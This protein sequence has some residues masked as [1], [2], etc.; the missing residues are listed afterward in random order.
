MRFKDYWALLRDTYTHWDE[1]KAQRMGAALACYAVISLAPLLVLVLA[2]AGLLFGPQAAAGE[3]VGEIEGTVG[4][5]VAEAL[6]GMIKEAQRPWS[7]TLATVLGL[8]VLL[9]GAS[10][11]FIELQDSMNTIWGVAPKPGRGAMGLVRDRFLSFTLILGTCFLLLVS[12][13]VTATLA[14]V[15][16]IW[17]PSSM[18]GGAWLWQ[19]L[20]AAVAFAVITLLFAL[21]FK[22]LPDAKVR[23]KDTWIGAASTALLFTLGKY[24]LGLYLVHGGVTSGYG[25]AGSLVVVLLWVFYSSQILLFGATF[26]RAYADRYGGG[27]VPADNAL[28]LSAEDRARQGASSSLKR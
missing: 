20:N 4:R 23:W 18:P 24:L 26:T 19:A 8:A 27:V 2:G 10:G 22:V 5:P 25:A 16:R 9:F 21:I 13:V 1:A 3:V 15:S 6:Q 28:P 12:L 17:A 14:A 11:V 7:C